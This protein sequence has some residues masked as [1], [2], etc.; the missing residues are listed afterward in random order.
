[1]NNK[2]QNLKF[3]ILDDE[4][5]TIAT[6]LMISQQGQ[7]KQIKLLTYPN[8]DLCSLEHASLISLN[9]P[10]FT[11]WSGRI[12]RQKDEQ[13]TFLADERID[14]NFR[15]YFRVNM[16]FESYIYCLDNPLKRLK[17]KCNNISCG[18]ISLFC[19]KPLIMGE[20]FEMV[21][22][23]T[24]PP[25]IVGVESLRAQPEAPN[26]YAFKFLNLLA[27]EEALIQESIFEF[28]LKQNTKRL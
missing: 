19:D 7:N 18:G 12:I 16:N 15:R 20:R 9:S 11:A 22:P 10:Q 2:S 6:C 4:R 8:V 21:V 13:A 26:L 1:M 17:I 3:A 24:E 5:H 28:D 23:C 27:Q 25:I 14:E